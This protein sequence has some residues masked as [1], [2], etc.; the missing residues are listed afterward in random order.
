MSGRK[1]EP[2]GIDH[3][4]GRPFGRRI[5]D[6]PGP[7]G[8]SGSNPSV[9]GLVRELQEAGREARRLTGGLTDFEFNW[10]P[11]GGRWSIAECFGHLNIV[12]SEM[13]PLFDSAVAEARRER[14][15]A[16]G[17]FK[18]GLVARWQLRRFEPPVRRRMRALERHVPPSNL[19]VREGVATLLDLFGQFASRLEAAGGLD[20]ARPRV[21]TPTGS[22]IQISLFES[23]LLFAAHARRHLEQAREV[24]ERADFGT[25]APPR[26]A[27]STG[28]RR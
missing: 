16:S 15:Y 12:G 22:V 10:R 28:R 18:T 6:G 14:W 7:V 21:E 4:F 19:G 2:G 25:G 13:L 5:P 24:R 26:P 1:P 9:V 3:L 11:G 17:P 8:S 27:P 20:L 23:L